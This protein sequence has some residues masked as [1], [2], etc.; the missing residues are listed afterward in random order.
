M[1][2]A[3]ELTIAFTT[4]LVEYEYLFT[5]YE[6]R[7]YFAYYLSAFYCRKTY[8]YFAIVVNQQYLFKFNSLATFRILDVVYEEL[9]AF[10]CLELLTVNLYDCVHFI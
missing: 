4:L 7:Y 1:T 8:C 3:I 6:W 2:I 9:L 5:L 10:F